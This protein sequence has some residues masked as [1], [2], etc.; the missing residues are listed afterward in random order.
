MSPSPT[1]TRN[2]AFEF[3]FDWN[4]NPSIRFRAGVF[5]LQIYMVDIDDDRLRSIANPS[6]LRVEDLLRFRIYDFT[7]QAGAGNASPQP[8]ALQLLFTAGAQTEGST[9]DRI[10]SPFVDS[11]GNQVPT[12]IFTEFSEIEE[13]SRAYGVSSGW[14]ASAGGVDQYELHNPGRFE[15]RAL[16]TL[17]EPGQPGRFY[18]VD[19]EMVVGAGGTGGSV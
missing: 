1:G 19:P 11:D 7:S 16:L 8:T 3:G 6:D 2:L 14:Q 12:L 17:S 10:F 4:T 13:P 9:S 5:L 18:E 15:L